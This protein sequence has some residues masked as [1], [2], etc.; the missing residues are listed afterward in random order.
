MTDRKFKGIQKIIVNSVDEENI[1]DV[2]IWAITDT[3]AE[4][5]VEILFAPNVI[6]GI[7]D[8]QWAKGYLVKVVHDGWTDVWDSYI[9][10][11]A[12]GVVLPNFSVIFDIITAGV[13]GTE[14]WVFQANKSY[15]S[16]RGEIGVK[17]EETRTPG[18]IF[19][20]C[21]GTVAITHP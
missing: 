20:L 11:S 12:A 6:E 3:F 2:D 16:N 8:K 18:T 10:E 4:D 7:G 19:V 17:R 9:D 15:V 21:F 13:A 1:M 14:V 5:L